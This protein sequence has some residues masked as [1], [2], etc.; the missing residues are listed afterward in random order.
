MLFQVT[1]KT[2]LFI[3][4]S[5][6]GLRRILYTICRCWPAET[7][8]YTFNR[9]A[10]S[11]TI[12]TWTHTLGTLRCRKAWSRR[13]WTLTTLSPWKKC[14]RNSQQM[15]IMPLELANRNLKMFFGIIHVIYSNR[16]GQKIWKTI[17][18]TVDNQQ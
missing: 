4:G 1:I 2:Y 17:Y 12:G 3:L 16:I 9:E 13:L 6:D 11:T 15:V 5:S 8:T 7:L 14:R 10:F 18:K